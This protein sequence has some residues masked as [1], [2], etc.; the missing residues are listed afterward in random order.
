MIFSSFEFIY[1]FFPVT[2]LGF[3][4]FRHLQSERAIIIW[5]IAASL[6]FYAYW[7]PPYLFLL[8]ASVGLNYALHLHIRQYRDPWVLGFGI[9]ANLSAIG[10]FKYA[11]FFASTLNAVSASQFDLGDIAL[12]LAISFF[13]FQQIAFLVE[14]YRGN[15]A[16]C[17][18]AKYTLFVVFFPQ[19]IAG[20]I[21]MQKD[22]VPQF[23]LSV[24]QNR[25]ALNVAVGLSIFI[26]GL[27]KKL[28]LA[29]GVAPYATAVFGAADG[30]EAIPFSMA[31]SGALAYTFQIYFDFSGYCDMAIGLA[32]CF[33]IRL[34]INFNSPYKAINI[35]DFWRR[36]HITLSH[37]L[38]DYL[39][40]P[41]GGNRGGKMQRYM[42]L[43]IT[44]LLGGLWHGASWTF[45]V[46]GGLHGLYLMI[47]HAWTTFMGGND[48]AS[49]ALGRLAGRIVTLLAVILAWVFF[50][51]ETF[52]GATSILAGMVGLNGGTP[53]KTLEAIALGVPESFV[54]FI[55]MAFVVWALPN[56]A[57]LAASY[58]PTLYF[59]KALGLKNWKPKDGRWSVFTKWR[60]TPMWIGPLAV[61]AVVSVVQMYRLGDLS[62]FIYYNF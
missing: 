54:L 4:V 19:L 23:R 27:F 8:L 10:Y 15:I 49:S 57:E 59:R 31:W 14:T 22:T 53:A 24:F 6:V 52:S 50:R 51:A 45:V 33:G 32:R 37:F 35:V 46:W 38:R 21:V 7:N 5:L 60:P 16:A 48:L 1:V 11:G 20:P 28:V 2:F 61:L 17:G 13:T 56:T 58:R 26:I 34:P 3:L 62:E 30:G 55:P 43:S 29:D 25:L 39:Y 42:N 47:N 18:F 41:L 44:M 36:W 12:P 40:I 9:T